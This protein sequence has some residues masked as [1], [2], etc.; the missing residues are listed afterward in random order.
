[1]STD[2]QAPDRPRPCACKYSCNGLRCRSKRL[3]RCTILLSS[4]EA[5]T[6]G[7]W[8]QLESAAVIARKYWTAGNEEFEMV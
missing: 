7:T 6:I 2:R 3:I 4:G 1:M 5:V 8:E